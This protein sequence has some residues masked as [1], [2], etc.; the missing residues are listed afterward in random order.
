LLCMIVP[1]GAINRL[2]RAV[3][4]QAAQ[5]SGGSRETFKNL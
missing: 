5:E 2:P 1:Q 4:N 3:T